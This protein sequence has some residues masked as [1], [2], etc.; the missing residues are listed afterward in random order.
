MSERAE[1]VHRS[2]LH[3]MIGNVGNSE[4]YHNI[5]EMDCVCIRIIWRFLAHMNQI[6]AGRKTYVWPF[7]RHGIQT[8]GGNG[9]LAG[10]QLNTF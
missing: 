4:G 7:T 5:F 1:H 6:G 10:C 9:L 3:A 2:K 8:N